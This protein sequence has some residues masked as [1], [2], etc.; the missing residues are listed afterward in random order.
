MP[1]T[2][3]QAAKVFID[4]AEF[5]KKGDWD[6]FAHHYAEDA[7]V[8]ANNNPAAEGRNAIVAFYKAMVTADPTLDFKY[9]M[10]PVHDSGELC[11]A[12]GT[13]EKF[14]KGAKVD[15]GNWVTVIRSRQGKSQIL[16]DIWNTWSP[17]K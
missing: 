10:D 4:S 6:A 2:Y 5:M 11:V 8:F 16:I 13:F 1:V 15:A 14:S 7:R 12:Q 3:E 17:K 9:T